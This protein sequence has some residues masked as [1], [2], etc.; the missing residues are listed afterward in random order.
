MITPPST[1]IGENNLSIDQSDQFPNAIESPQREEQNPP[2]LYKR[3]WYCL[4]M[5]SLNNLLQSIEVLLLTSLPS[6]V[7]EYYGSD[8]MSMLRQNQVLSF[9][10]IAFIP[11]MFWMFFVEAFSHNFRVMTL[12][13][14]FGLVACCVFRLIPTWIPPL[15]KYCFPFLMLGQMANNYGA[16]FSFAIPSKL[17]ALWFPAKERPFATTIA[18]QVSP[19]GIALS[20]LIMPALVKNGSQLPFA[21]HLCLGLQVLCSLVIV[22]CFPAAPPHTPPPTR[23]PSNLT[24]QTI[25]LSLHHRLTPSMPLLRTRNDEES[26]VLAAGWAGWSA[27]WHRAELG[28]EHRLLLHIAGS[29]GILWWLRCVRPLRHFCRWCHGD[30]VVVA[31][32]APS[33]ERQGTDVCGV[34]AGTCDDRPADVHAAHLLLSPA[35]P[36][37]TPCL[38]VCP[39]GPLRVHR[40]R[41]SSSFYD[42]SAELTFPVSESISGGFVSGFYFVAYFAVPLLFSATGIGWMSFI[43]FLFLVGVV[44]VLIFVRID[45]RRSRVEEGGSLEDDEKQEKGAI[46]IEMQI[47]NQNEEMTKA[48]PVGSEYE[49]HHAPSPNPSPISERFG[50]EQEEIE[51]IEI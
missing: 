51:R 12:H 31:D 22:I 15:K 43:T 35:P 28:C 10:A 41:P 50:L 7:S 38:V 29:D 6:S 24:A 9:A 21:L 4:L 1:S 48:A 16:A 45:Y 30:D 33:E 23:N 44:L 27:I 13:S 34:R 26:A 20:Y 3:R 19:V 32:K 42:L 5:F 40:R 49:T 39:R 47:N 36:P 2:K 18:T 17:G 11:F 8:V 25:K 46:S 14:T 37:R